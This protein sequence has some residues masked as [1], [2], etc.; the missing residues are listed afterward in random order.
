MV[1]NYDEWWNEPTSSF[2]APTHGLYV[3]HL[4][5]M[6][7]SSSTYNRAD[8]YAKGNSVQS[9]V[10][11]NSPYSAS[12]SVIVELEYFDQV[13]VRLIRGSLRESGDNNLH[14]TGYLLA[15]IPEPNSTLS[16]LERTKIF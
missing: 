5:I 8:I 11:Y 9:C 7:A 1:M 10:A 13:Y 15:E 6:G 2:V 14:F 4:S 12:A 3:F 16:E